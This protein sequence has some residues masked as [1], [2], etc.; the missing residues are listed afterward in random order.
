MPGFKQNEKWKHLHSVHSRYSVGRLVLVQYIF[1]IEDVKEMGKRNESNFRHNTQQHT[2]QC[3]V[4]YIHFNHISF[5][6]AEREKQRTNAATA[7][8]WIQFECEKCQ[9]FISKYIKIVC[10]WR[11]Y[12]NYGKYVFTTF[13]DTGYD[14]GYCLVL[15]CNIW[16]DGTCCTNVQCTQQYVRWSEVFCLL[17]YARTFMER[18]V[19]VCV[20][21]FTSTEHKHTCFILICHWN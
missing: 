21:R 3:T 7:K 14:V 6:V 19:C 15:T 8:R 5:S 2:V 10:V 18:C 13:L 4:N 20:C 9:L 1:W 17:I 16:C 11:A 12:V